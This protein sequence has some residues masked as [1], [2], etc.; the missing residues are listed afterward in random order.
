MEVGRRFVRSPSQ[1]ARSFLDEDDDE[2]L[3]EEE[4]VSGMSGTR[5]ALR[6]FSQNSLQLEHRASVASLRSRGTLASLDEGTVASVS[7][8]H[9]MD[10]MSP[11]S[12]GG[13]VV[14][15]ESESSGSEEENEGTDGAGERE[16]ESGV[17]DANAAM[18]LSFVKVRPHP[19]P[20]SLPLGLSTSPSRAP[21]L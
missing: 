9:G 19:L 8:K 10:V 15:V 6:I 17:N 7:H 14:H 20:D 16:G 11:L 13:D 3:D 18:S 5:S 2:F 4:G 12:L 21:S 1:E